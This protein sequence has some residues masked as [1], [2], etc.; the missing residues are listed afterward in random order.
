[1]IEMCIQRNIPVVMILSGGYLKINSKIIADSIE[2]L[3]NKFGWFIKKL[4][5]IIS[6][7]KIAI[8]YT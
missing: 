5:S 1:M 2:N 8:F 6:Q 4:F 7:L 3:V